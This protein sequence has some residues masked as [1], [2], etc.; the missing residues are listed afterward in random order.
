MYDR[1]WEA[2]R[3]KFLAINNECYA[4]GK[5]AEVVDHLKPHQGDKYLF[6]KTDNHIPL[7]IVCH[8][9][10]TSLFDRRYRAGG[11]ISK[12]IEWLNRKRVPGIEWNFKRVKVL[13][14]Y[15]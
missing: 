5:P 13:P 11:S 4:C 1:T 9:T 6:E 7:C 14:E 12:K 10:V 15:G 2:Y 8:N 3:K